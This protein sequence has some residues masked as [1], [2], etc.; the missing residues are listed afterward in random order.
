MK[1][2]RSRSKFSVVNNYYNRAVKVAE[3]SGILADES[4]RSQKEILKTFFAENHI[5]GLKNVHA[6]NKL[7]TAVAGTLAAT[8]VIGG[9]F[10]LSHL[11]PVASRP[12]PAVGS[13]FSSGQTI[14]PESSNTPDV[15]YTPD[16]SNTQEEQT[17]SLSDTIPRDV[18]KAD[19]LKDF[20]ERYA[21]EYNHN[22]D[23]AN[24][25]ADDLE[26]SFRH[27]NYILEV[28]VGDEIRYVSHGAYPDMIE[29]YLRENNIEYRGI[30]NNISGDIPVITI[31]E[32]NDS[33]SIKYDDYGNPLD[34]TSTRIGYA[35]R[36]NGTWVPLFDGN[37]PRTTGLLDPNPPDN[38]LLPGLAEAFY[39][40][41]IRDP[42]KTDRS[43]YINNLELYY[44]ANPYNAL[45]SNVI[46]SGERTD[47]D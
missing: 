17:M 45:P 20:K 23:E 35:A 28:Q 14:K 4:K 29:K 47:R 25:N 5:N 40:G 7:Y 30:R 27:H 39:V 26:V 31:M 32:Q 43:G 18:K 15:S 16:I 6:R 9:L 3:E 41:Y 13:I 44:I 46:I 8:L 42:N 12:L 1:N 21:A 10:V 22:N 38:S 33:S 36:V 2:I 11:K 24:L 19:V 34:Y 37:N